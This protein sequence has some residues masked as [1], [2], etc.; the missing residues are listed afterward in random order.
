M[1]IDAMR[2]CAEAPAT[3]A[4]RDLA[5][6]ATDLADAYS[7]DVMFDWFLGTDG[8]RS[9]ALG[10]FFALIVA[11]GRARWRPDRAAGL[12]RRCGVV[13]AVRDHQ[14]DVAQLRNSGALPTLLDA[15][16][17]GRFSLTCSRCGPTWTATTSMDPSPPPTCGS[18][19]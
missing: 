8:R 7:D 18:W 6:V 9:A 19:A 5:G 2:R 12:G 14:A 17:L 10:R 11:H 15:T 13:D 4:P 16:G 3:A 1:D